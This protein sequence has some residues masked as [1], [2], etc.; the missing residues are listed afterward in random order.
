MNG[1][2]GRLVYCKPCFTRR[3]RRDTDGELE[4]DVNSV[5]T[6][7]PFLE[8]ITQLGGIKRLN[9]IGCQKVFPSQGPGLYKRETCILFRNCSVRWLPGDSVR[10]ETLSRTLSALWSVT[11]QYL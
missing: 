10:R 3:R 8:E 6:V 1:A 2:V 7:F 11:R 5:E 4:K 9:E